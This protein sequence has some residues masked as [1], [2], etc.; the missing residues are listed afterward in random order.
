MK[1][2]C[3]LGLAARLEPRLYEGHYG[4]EDREVDHRRGDGTCRQPRHAPEGMAEALQTGLRGG[5]GDFS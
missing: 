2:V 5:L 3:D 4:P 1:A